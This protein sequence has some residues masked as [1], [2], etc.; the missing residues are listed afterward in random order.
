MNAH[1]STDRQMAATHN[2]TTQSRSTSRSV[3][4]V[5]AG[6]LTLTLLAVSGF[7][8]TA[9]S[10]RADGSAVVSRSGAIAARPPSPAPTPPNGRILGPGCPAG[11]VLIM[12][13]KPIYDADGLFVID[14]EL[15]PYCMPEDLEPAG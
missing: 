5:S 3:A 14:W 15:V 6:L 9:P 10:A 4:L 1:R 2:P 12:W 7:G 8:P 11:T 13:E